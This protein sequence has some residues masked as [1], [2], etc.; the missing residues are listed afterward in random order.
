MPA[1]GCALGFI[2]VSVILGKKTMS[3]I[4]DLLAESH[5]RWAKAMKRAQGIEDIGLGPAMRTYYIRYLPAGL[6]ILFVAGTVFGVKVFGT[7]ASGLA[8]LWLSGFPLRRWVP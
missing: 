5:D 8:S 7:A 3:E 6:A 4:D 2:T 1:A